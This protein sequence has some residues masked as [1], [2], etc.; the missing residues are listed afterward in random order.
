[1]WG[2]FPRNICENSEE[3]INGCEKQGGLI[4]CA[5]AS[6]DKMLQMPE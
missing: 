6:V 5:D 2:L 1:M 4:S 3:C